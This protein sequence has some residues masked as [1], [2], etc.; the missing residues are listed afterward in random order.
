MSEPPGSPN[1]SD[2]LIRLARFIGAFLAAPLLYLVLWQLAADMLLPREAGSSR[3]VMIN[4][5]SVAIP[6]LGVLATIYLAGPRAGRIMGSVVMMVFF[7]FLYLSSAVTLELLPPLLTVLGIAL[8]VL[9]SRRMP[10]MTP[11]LAELKA[12]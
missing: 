10:T 1:S 12:P 2:A 7:L 3:L 5:F 9:I 6:C 4:L 11:D 8:A